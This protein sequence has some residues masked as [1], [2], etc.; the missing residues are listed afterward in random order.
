M[1]QKLAVCDPLGA[2]AIVLAV[3][4]GDGV[5]ELEADRAGPRARVP[6]AGGHTSGG[7]RAA[8]GR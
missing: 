6:A 3:A 1:K 4:L 8:R 5:R 7:D 2:C